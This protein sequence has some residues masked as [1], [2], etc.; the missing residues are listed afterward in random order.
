MT[1]MSG[2]FIAAA[3]MIIFLDSFYGT[4]RDF[5]AAALW[6]FTADVG[7]AKVREYA[8]PLASR[9]PSLSPASTK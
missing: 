6:V 7:L 4:F 5:F 3:G 8:Q 2:V 9:T 1:A